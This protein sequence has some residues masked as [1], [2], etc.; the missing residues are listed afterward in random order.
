[1]SKRSRRSYRLPVFSGYR[2]DETLQMDSALLTQN[3]LSVSDTCCCKNRVRFPESTTTRLTH[4]TNPP[5]FP[6]TPA[7]TSIHV[8]CERRQKAT[9]GSTFTSRNCTHRVRSAS[10]TI[11]R[12]LT[13]MA[14]FNQPFSPSSNDGDDRGRFTLRRITPQISV[15]GSGPAQASPP[16]RAGN[17]VV[18]PCG[19]FAYLCSRQEMPT[20]PGYC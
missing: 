9:F 8:V 15:V 16:C 14:L 13:Y 4:S 17:P 19:A 12:P 20:G 6:P 2:L 7:G 18:G 1:V 3:S 11:P 5:S 10:Y